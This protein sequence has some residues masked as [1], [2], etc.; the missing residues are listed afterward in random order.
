MA[1]LID[2]LW[3]SILFTALV[4]VLA[5]IAGGHPGL[6]LWLW[7]IAALKFLLPFGLLY[8]LGG[9]IGF[10]VR[11]HAIPPPADLVEAS[12][13]VRPWFA[14][15]QTFEPASIG[16]W[17]GLSLSLAAAAACA[18]WIRG[19]L[20]KATATASASSVAPQDKLVGMWLATTLASVTMA[21]VAAPMLSGALDDRLHRQVALRID[22]E[23]LRA[24]GITLT[25]IP[26]Q[27]GGRTEVLATA[28]GV[29]IH[30]VNLQDLVAM[31]YGIGEFEV[32]GG[33][34]PWLEH[35]HYDVRVQGRVFAPEVFD[36]YSL[37]EPVTRY[38]NQEFGVSIRVNGNCQEPC[39]NQESFVVER[40]P[41]LLSKMI[42]GEK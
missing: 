9:W 38:L 19:R 11:H 29:E 32:F 35:P 30:H 22:I 7:R 42:G 28:Q 12:I 27:F 41:W 15:A 23:A 2:H 21:V 10:P 18:L 24:A 34:L 6:R 36:A 20:A 39:L 25:P 3:Q 26:T 31:V 1:S 17:L 14:P 37:R 16:L 40:I 13:A 4:S 5:A 8:A 33:A